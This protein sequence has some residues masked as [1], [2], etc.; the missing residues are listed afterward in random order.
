MTSHRDGSIVVWSLDREDAVFTPSPPPPATYRS[1]MQHLGSPVSEQQAPFDTDLADDMV[2]TRPPPDRKGRAATTNPVS[3]WRVSRKRASSVVGLAH[4]EA[5]TDF[6]FSP[7]LQHCAVTSEDG[8]LRIID[9]P[10]ERLVD[11]YGPSAAALSSLTVAGSYFGSLLCVV[12]SPDGR[13]VLTGGQDDLISVW[14]PAEQRLVARAQG[15]ASFVTALALDE[16]STEVRSA[17]GRAALTVTQRTLRFAS[18]SEDCQLIFVRRAWVLRVLSAAV[19]TQSRGAAET[20]D[21]TGV[22]AT[23]LD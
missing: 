17:A 7:D 18:V 23:L 4:L 14:S 5:V 19:G 13:F 9:V 1:A 8:C 3:H 16:R 21:G 2:V 15:H 22:L 6:A 20:Q 11:A 12:W 10:S